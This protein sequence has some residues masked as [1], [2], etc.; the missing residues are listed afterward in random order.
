[1]NLIKCL[2]L[3][4]SQSLNMKRFFER[5]SLCLSAKS[6]LKGGRGQCVSELEW[7]RVRFKYERLREFSTV[8]E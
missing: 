3:P 7:F 1:M 2:P 8:F 5:G 6:V 4:A